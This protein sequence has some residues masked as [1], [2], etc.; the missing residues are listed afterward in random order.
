MFPL[1]TRHSVRLVFPLSARHLPRASLPASS[2]TSSGMVSRTM[3]ERVTSPSSL[4]PAHAPDQNPPHASVSPSYIRY[5]AGCCEPLLGDGPSRHYLCNPCVGAW[6]PT[7]QCSPGALARFFPEDNGL[8]S[9]VTS[10]AHQTTPAMQLQQ[11]TIFG[12]A[13]IL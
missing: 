11:E 1:F 6:T 7:P 13:V 5:F 9:D 12:A 3:S 4:L 2:V 10:S 8:T